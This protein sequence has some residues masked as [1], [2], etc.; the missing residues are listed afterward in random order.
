MFKNDVSITSSREPK[1]R[2]YTNSG[3]IL[4]GRPKG[5]PGRLSGHSQ[6]HWPIKRRITVTEYA[7]PGVLPTM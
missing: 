3:Y 4:K 1:P 7:M 6:Y 5:R 2:A